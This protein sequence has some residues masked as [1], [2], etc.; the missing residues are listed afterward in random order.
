MKVF[1]KDFR[2]TLNIPQSPL[3]PSWEIFVD[4]KSQVSLLQ[5]VIKQKMKLLET[6]GKRPSKLEQLFEALLTIPPTSVEA[7]GAF[8]AAGLF[9]EKLLSRLSDK[10]VSAL[11]FL[12]CHYTI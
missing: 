2:H 5:T 6:T 10:S 8:F 3:P 4:N 1:S 11:S 12:C 7:E 9:V